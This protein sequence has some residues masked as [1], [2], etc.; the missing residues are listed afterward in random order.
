MATHKTLVVIV[1]VALVLGAVPAA[2]YHLLIDTKTYTYSVEVGGKPATVTVVWVISPHLIDLGHQYLIKVGKDEYRTRVRFTNGS[3]I[4][5]TTSTEPR[6][7]WEVDGHCYVAC[8]EG[9]VNWHIGELQAN[10]GLT[11]VSRP[12]L[13]AGEIPWNL[14]GPGDDAYWKADFEEWQKLMKIRDGLGK[15]H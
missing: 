12:Q 10:G 2:L 8:E 11:P 9:H 7:I 5:F 6:A 4:R 15:P 13:P 14:V 1:L 3:E